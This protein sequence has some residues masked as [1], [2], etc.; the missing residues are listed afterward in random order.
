MKSYQKIIILGCLFLLTC[1]GSSFAMI[2]SQRKK[3]YMAQ[4]QKV[5]SIKQ[6]KEQEYNSTRERIENKLAEKAKQSKSTNLRSSARQLIVNR[7]IAYKAEEL[8]EVLFNYDT[9]K[10]YIN[11]YKKVRD[12]L[13]KKAL[14]NQALFPSGKYAKKL[15]GQDV[16]AHFNSMTLNSGVE[17]EDDNIPVILRVR[18]TRYSHGK[19]ILYEDEMFDTVYNNADK[20]F[21]SIT[22]LGKFPIERS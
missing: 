22:S 2:T 8:C 11:R 12:I 13:D 9:P 15:I 14:S 21:I 6:R 19:P 18:Y 16:Q 3:M 10:E 4:V 5:E 17:D 1:A 20:K 7:D